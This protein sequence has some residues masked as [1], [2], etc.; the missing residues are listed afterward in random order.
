MYYYGYKPHAVC[1]LTGVFKTFDITK[2]S[3]HDIHYLQDTKD[4]LNDCVLLGDR[5]YISAEVQLKLFENQKIKLE[6][7]MRANQ[8]NYRKQ[9]YILRKSR[10]QIE[11]LFYSFATNS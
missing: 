1:S 6:V 7:P 8:H 9:V 10:K 5:G 4:Q 3:A 11:T 2:A